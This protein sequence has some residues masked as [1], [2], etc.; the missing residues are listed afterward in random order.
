M[1]F[2]SLTPPCAALALLA[3]CASPSGSS[4]S[5]PTSGTG[6][7]LSEQVYTDVNA[8]RTGSQLK[9]LKR[10]GGLDKLAAQ[11]SAHMC[12]NRG[13]FSL[14]GTNVSHS[15]YSERATAA[16][17]G[18]GM[19]NYSENVG[20][21]DTTGSNSASSRALVTM[22]K[23]SPSHHEAMRRNEWTHTGVATH[24]ADD[25]TVFATQIFATE[26]SSQMARMDRFSTSF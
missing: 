9:P 23:N 8:Y 2:H 5:V 7:S 22:W 17:K 12:A 24:V 14:H 19:G 3:S 25:G 6:S 16:I 20:W 15:G 10:H 26:N 18:Y 21:T 1:K 13:K 4:V 11:H